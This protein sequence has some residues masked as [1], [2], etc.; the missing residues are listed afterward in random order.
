MA[1]VGFGEVSPPIQNRGGDK[2]WMLRNAKKFKI[3]GILLI[4]VSLIRLL[5]KFAN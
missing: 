1:G 3:I 2:E 4:T 5:I